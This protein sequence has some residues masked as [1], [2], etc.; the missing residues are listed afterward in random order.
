MKNIVSVLLA[1]TLAICSATALADASQSTSFEKLLNERFP[2]TVGAKIEPAFPGFWSVVK[3]SEV[4]FVRED[5]SVLISG[6]VVDLQ[7]NQSLGAKLRAANRPHVAIKDLDTR[8]AIRFGSGGRHLYVFSDPDCPHC[9]R[10]EGE[11][12]K[13]HDVEV[14][15]FPY[16]LAG[17]HPTAR[18]TAESIWC[19]KDRASAWR[20]YMTAGTAPTATNCDNPID[21]NVALGERLQV[22]GTPALI[23][24][25]GSV[26]PGAVSVE[27]IE[28]QLAAVAKK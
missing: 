4:F 9:R 12:A 2:A 1:A 7:T 13:L 27:R 10:L 3:G 5:L 18:A 25:D 28:A 23:F 21:R 17:L 19:Q 6:D 15:V 20:A 14:F 16:P 11:L 8:D 26:I 22:M 24:D